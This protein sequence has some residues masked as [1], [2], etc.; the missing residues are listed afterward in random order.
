M[1]Q[2]YDILGKLLFWYY[3]LLI[4]IS[5]WDKNGKETINGIFV[6]VGGEDPDERNDLTVQIYCGQISYA[7]Q[8]LA[9]CL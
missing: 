7:G 9:P 5:L 3:L 4:F 6:L 8:T 1:L 2:T